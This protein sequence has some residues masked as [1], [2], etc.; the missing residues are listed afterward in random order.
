MHLYGWPWNACHTFAFK[1][2]QWISCHFNEKNAN[3]KLCMQNVW[4]TN[5]MSICMYIWTNSTWIIY[6]W[7]W[8]LLNWFIRNISGQ[9]DFPHQYRELFLL[10][11]VTRNLFCSRAV[12][13]CLDLAYRHWNLMHT[14][15][16]HCVLI[17]LSIFFTV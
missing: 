7:T 1:S 16:Y 14:L 6:A 17:C 12:H 8:S 4:S 11:I 2:L 5:I 13:N 15:I 3:M 9:F 10:G